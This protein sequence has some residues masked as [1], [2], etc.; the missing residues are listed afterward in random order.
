MTA[1]LLGLSLEET[2]RRIAKGDIGI[3]ETATA[4]LAALEGQGKALNAVARVEREHALA[5]AR[6]LEKVRR[7]GAG[8]GALF[9]VP[10]AHKDLYGR[11]GWRIDGGSRQLGP[12]VAPATAFAIDRLDKAGA[13]DVGRLNTVEFG[14][15]TMG[16][17]AVTGN[18]RNPWNPEHVTGGSSS[19]S[20]AAVGA[21]LVAAAL[22]S[23][24]GGSI[25]LPAGACA[26]VGLKPTPGLIGRS[27]VLP[28]AYSFDTVGPLT[29]TVR[30]AALMLQALAGYDP[31]DSAS[32]QVAIP[33][34]L[35]GIERGVKDVRIG[36]PANYFLEPATAEVKAGVEGARKALATAGA[37]I[38]EVRID[39]IAEANRLT[40]LMIAVEAAAVH[41]RWLKTRAKVYG[42]Q[43]LG[44]LL[45]GLFVPADAYV[46]AAEYRRRF[47]ARTMAT[48]FR[49]ADVLL[50][51]TW[52]YPIPTLA[53]T[54]VGAAQGFSDMIV[55]S[56][57][58][59]RPI[60]FLGCPS[61]TLPCGF[62]ANGLPLSVQLVGRPFEEALLLRVARAYEA[63]RG[64]LGRRPKVSVWS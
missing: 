1:G 64:E 37:S 35:A 44:R 28:L 5:E 59:V 61:I 19:G 17:N 58:C 55:A 3:V 57:H 9:G 62:S 11:K 32:R 60:N 34:Y 15:G 33:D 2:A 30:D 12:Y 16:H 25:R 7:D 63:A 21:G 10:L 31:G 18:V 52:P 27:G 45:T 43:T 54:D 23:D 49:E 51:P 8:R 29:R 53:E 42:P 50:V 39:G 56:G 24:T 4:T 47:V 22:G 13:I 36:W 20:G 40:A 48:T 14:L 38:R 41:S 46:R 6:R 26:T